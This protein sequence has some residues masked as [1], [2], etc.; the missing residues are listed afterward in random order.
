[1]PRY[2]FDLHND[3]DV[4]D[5]EGVE[6]PNLNAALLHALHEARTMI[7]AS[8][9]DRPHRFAPSHRFA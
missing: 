4:R 1:M 6:L 5:D 8:I 3:M 2:F 7:Q 9:A